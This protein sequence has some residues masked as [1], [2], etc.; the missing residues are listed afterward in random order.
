M[1]PTL[2]VVLTLFGTTFALGIVR[3]RHLR[4]LWSSEKQIKLDF[5]PSRI[6]GLDVAALLLVFLFRSVRHSLTVLSKWSA[7]R[8]VHNDMSSQNKDEL[9]LTMPLRI[10]QADFSAYAKA[11]RSSTD[12][13][14]GWSSTQSLFFLSALTEP[15]MLLLLARSSCNL[16]PL[17]AVNVKNRFELHADMSTKE[18]LLALKGAIVTVRL[19]NKVRAVKRGF[20]VD[21]Q[22]DLD[23]P[24][25]DSGE[26]VKVFRQ[27]FTILQFAKTQADSTH[28]AAVQTVAAAVTSSDPIHFKVDYD[29]PTYWAR[30]C[31]D[32][33]PIH[34]SAVAARVF[35]FQGKLAHGN[36]MGALASGYME[37]A[38]QRGPLCME[39]RFRRPV[40]V[41]AQLIIKISRVA[42]GQEHSHLTLFEILSKNR[43]CIDGSIGDLRHMAVA[44]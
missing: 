2:A 9:S 31:K 37:G 44:D 23:A 35:G 7:D 32:Y 41:P 30:L 21:L 34:T 12:E 16:R 15:A 11:V 3:L 1:L 43:S 19:F 22:V 13:C 24:N 33:N 26:L 40:V 4:P 42:E 8:D 36:H 14:D 25:N 27:K 29:D 6:S 10:R 28:I 39:I 18:G 5:S 20:E 38:N 17:G